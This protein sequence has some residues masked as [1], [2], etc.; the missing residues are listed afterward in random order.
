MLMHNPAVKWGAMKTLYFALISVLLSVL[1]TTLAGCSTGTT[2]YVRITPSNG[3]SILQLFSQANEL[4][5]QWEEF[6]PNDKCSDDG[7]Y[8][9]RYKIQSGLAEHYRGI[10]IAIMADVKNDLLFFSFGHL[11]SRENISLETKKLFDELMDRMKNKF[12]SAQII[13]MELSGANSS[14]AQLLQHQLFNGG[15]VQLSCI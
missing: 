14:D 13:P 3:Q 4:V 5:S 6:S 2:E 15:Q 9:Y 8:Y 10:N 12:G 7:S 1:L 11:E